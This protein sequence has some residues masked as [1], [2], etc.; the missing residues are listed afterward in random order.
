MTATCRTPIPPEEALRWFRGDL[1]SAGEDALEQH[2]FACESCARRLEGFHRLGADVKRV[3]REGRVPVAVTSAL[4]EQAAAEGMHLRSYRLGDGGEVRCTASPRDDAVILRLAVDTGADE[5]VDL[6]AKVSIFGS[7]EGYVQLTEDVVVDRSRGEVTY[8]FPGALIR[9]YP[10]SRWDVTTR[11][12]GEAGTRLGT[13]ALVHTPWEELPE[14][15][16]ATR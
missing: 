16:R 1:P 9:A 5:T 15:E 7:G 11:I 14:S 10:R 13:Y 4:L 6:E 2:L 3:V 8:L 12:H